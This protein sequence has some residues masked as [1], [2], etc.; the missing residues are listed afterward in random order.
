[1]PYYWGVGPL[2]SPLERRWNNAAAGPPALWR[3]LTAMS[4]LYLAQGLVAGFGM[5]VLIP[6]LQAA[7]ADVSTQA[8]ILA[9]GGLPWALKI[10]WAPALDRLAGPGTG[11]RRR[12]VVIAL[13]LLCAFFLQYESF[14]RSGER[15]T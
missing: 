4:T 5:F 11:Y 14:P 2:P 8:W 1:M 3:S 6:L 9:W 7:G 13:Q 12:R 15:L 10:L